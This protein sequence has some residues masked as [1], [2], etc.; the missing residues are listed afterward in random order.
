MPLQRRLPKRGF[1]NPTRVEYN[2]VNLKSFNGL[3]PSEPVTGEL[4]RSKAIVKRR[5]P[6]KLLAMGDV[7]AAYSVKLDK[8]SRAARQKI[9][10]AG[11]SVEEI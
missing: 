11:G 7:S 1:H 4:L 3:D 2:V 9:V 5:G 10:A 8:V 6:I